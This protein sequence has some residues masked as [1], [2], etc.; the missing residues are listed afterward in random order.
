MK[1]LQ[2]IENERVNPRAS[3]LERLGRALRRGG[4]RFVAEDAEGG[5]GVRRTGNVDKMA[6]RGRLVAR[7]RRAPAPL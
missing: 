7:G 6:G 2:R 5:E 1:A 3:T 4:V